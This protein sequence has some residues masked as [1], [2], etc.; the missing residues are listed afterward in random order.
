MSVIIDLIS[1]KDGELKRFLENY[2]DSDIS[3]DSELSE[4]M[5]TYKNPLDSVDI[6]T[7]LVDN[8]SDF[9]IETWISIDEGMFLKVTNDNID[10]I[11]RYMYDRF[12]SNLYN[13]LA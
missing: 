6:I 13:N 1:N 7:V 2:Y 10:N 9:E 11:I 12:Q 4:W 5:Y 8:S 3:I